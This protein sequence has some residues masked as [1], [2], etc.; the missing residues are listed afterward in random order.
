[1]YNKWNVILKLHNNILCYIYK[2]H[3]GAHGT[4]SPLLT[5]IQ[6]QSFYFW[7]HMGHFE[8]ALEMSVKYLPAVL[9]ISLLYWR[10]TSSICVLEASP[11]LTSTPKCENSTCWND[12]C[13]CFQNTPFDQKEYFPAIKISP[14]LYFLVTNLF[15]NKML[16]CSTHSIIVVQFGDEHVA[17]VC[18]WA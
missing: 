2:T 1:M 8:E 16:P 15:A 11:I 14:K 9:I 6:R 10:S 13:W 17:N 3:S 5:D 7:S 18:T 4:K 12:K